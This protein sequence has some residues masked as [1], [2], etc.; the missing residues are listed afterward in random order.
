MSQEDT[1][2]KM[3]TKELKFRLENVQ[4]VG[5]VSGENVERLYVR[6]A[7]RRLEDPMRFERAFCED[8]ASIRKLTEENDNLKSRI[9]ELEGLVK[10]NCGSTVQTDMDLEALKKLER[11]YDTSGIYYYDAPVGERRYHRVDDALKELIAIKEKRLSSPSEDGGKELAIKFR[12]AVA[13]RCNMLEDAV[14]N[15]NMSDRTDGMKD[16]V[17]ILKEMLNEFD[18]ITKEGN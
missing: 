10:A 9:A 11:F 6:E 18:R 3:S 8:E 16:Q 2:R 4:L 15:A 7:V 5:V 1:I 12:T 14:L 17:E 13:D